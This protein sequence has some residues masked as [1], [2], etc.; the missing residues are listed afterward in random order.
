MPEQTT[1]G[2]EALPCDLYR[3]FGL[4]VESA[5]PLPELD[6]ASPGNPAD[7]VIGEG[8]IPRLLEGDEPAGLSVVGDGAVLNIPEVGRYWIRG[9]SEITVERFAGASER[10]VRLFLLGSAFA[11]I[12]HQR[13]LLPLHANAVEIDGKAVAFMGHSGAGKST[14]AAW[15]HDHGFKVLADD[16]CVVRTADG[17]AFAHAGIPRLRL[18]Q[19]ALELTGRTSTEYEASFD[20][21]DKYNV[22]TQ[23]RPSADAVELSHVYL[24]TQAA[25]PAAVERLAGIEAVDALVAN[26][27]RGAYLPLMRETQRHLFQCLALLE[28][29]PVFRAQRVWGMADFDEQARRLE[30]HARAIMAGRGQP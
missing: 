1:A 6:Q 28:K 12:L 3:I 23:S 17:K 2:G 11:A 25:G 21:T 15:F 4:D 24:L 30:A 29:V 14:L 7:V 19:D 16:V 9:G 18:W 22:P 5:I 8:A 13:A 20:D 26:T 10:N 27:Y